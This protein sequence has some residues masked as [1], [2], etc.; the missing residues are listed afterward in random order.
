LFNLALII[1]PNDNPV[2]RRVICT[3]RSVRAG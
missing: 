2:N 3:D 1:A